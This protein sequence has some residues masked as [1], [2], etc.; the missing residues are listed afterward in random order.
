LTTRRADDGDRHRYGS[1]TTS[2]PPVELS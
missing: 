2:W 1:L